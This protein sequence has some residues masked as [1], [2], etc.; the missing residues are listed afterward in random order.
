LIWSAACNIPD[1]LIETVK[2]SVGG[3]ANMFI[4]ENN[5]GN[6]PIDAEAYSEALA[7]Q[8]EIYL[9]ETEE[10]LRMIL[11]CDD[12]FLPPNDS[13]DP[14][15]EDAVEE[16]ITGDPDDPPLIEATVNLILLR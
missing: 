7:S 12:R 14:Q 6:L 3:T 4:W 16:L 11:E 8:E 10:S 13:S 2:R 1:R 9:E 5:E 15:Q